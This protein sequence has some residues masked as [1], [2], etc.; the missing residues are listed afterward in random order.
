MTPDD[1][2]LIELLVDDELP[3]EEREELL[4]RCQREPDGWRRLAEGFLEAQA[5]RRSLR[6]SARPAI[7]S[8]RGWLGPLCA[9]ASVVLAFVLG[10]A[11]PEASVD[12]PSSPELPEIAE[13]ELVPE[14]ESESPVQQVVE[15]PRWSGARQWHQVTFETRVEQGF[16]RYVTPDPLPGFV[17]EALADAGHRVEF[18]PRW[19]QVPMGEGQSVNLPI[20]ETLI[21]PKQQL[22]L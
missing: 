5:L 8:G 15:M 22:Q 19:V 3:V 4:A 21:T 10:L 7:G 11:W 9:A 6:E 17:L 1:Q 18:A 2:L 13:V 14:P 16:V 12:R 20:T